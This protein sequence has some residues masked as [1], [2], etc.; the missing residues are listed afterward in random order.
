[1]SICPYSLVVSGF[2]TK[3][4]LGIIM[5]KFLFTAIGNEGLLTLTSGVSDFGMIFDIS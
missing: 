2:I 4:N 1:M 3:R 5:Y